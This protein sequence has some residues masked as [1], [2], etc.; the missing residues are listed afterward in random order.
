MRPPLS[1]SIVRQTSDALGTV[2]RQVFRWT[3]G[4]TF[5]LGS[6]Y[7]LNL[8]MF[9]GWASGG[10]PTPRPE[11]HRAWFYRFGFSAVGAFLLGLGIIWRLR[12][13]NRPY[14]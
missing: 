13:S 5:I 7:L 12:R 4:V 6:L 2:V 11:W 10:P 1:G 3:L 9:H 8:A 14:V